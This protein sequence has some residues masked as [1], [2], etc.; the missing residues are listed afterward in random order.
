MTNKGNENFCFKYI[1]SYDI[2]NILNVVSK[3]DLE[4][5]I[6]TSRQ[7]QDDP[8]HKNTESYFILGNVGNKMGSR[9]SLG[10]KLV[11]VNLCRDKVLW[12]MVKPIIQDLKKFHEGVAS[13]AM[14]V[15]LM[16]E[17]DIMPHI[18][19]SEYLQFVRRNHLAIKTNDSVIFHVGEETKNIATGECWEINNS[20]IHYVENNGNEERIHLIVDI[21][22]DKVIGRKYRVGEK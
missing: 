20:K 12:E 11:T 13:S 5:R 8:T 1:S 18:D 17:K 22:P 7:D 14:I 6:N 10:E 15:K 9:W 2:S 4:W 16:P 21:M 19:K 3:F